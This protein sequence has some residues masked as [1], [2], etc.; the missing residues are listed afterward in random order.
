MLHFNQITEQT[1]CY[2]LETTDRLGGHL[3]LAVVAHVSVELC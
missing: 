2:A 1:A 3:S